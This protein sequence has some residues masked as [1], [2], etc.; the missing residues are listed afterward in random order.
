MKPWSV[1]GRVAALALPAAIALAPGARAQEGAA[2]PP[3]DSIV[4]VTVAPVQASPGASADAHV[5]ISVANGWH[6]NAN[7]ANPDYMIATVVEIAPV[8]GIKSGK[9]RYPAARQERLAFDP[10][11]IAVYTGDVEARVP[12]AIAADVRAGTQHLRGKLKFQS[13]ND[14]VC[15][16][17]AT[18]GFDLELRVA[19]APARGA[20]P[21]APAAG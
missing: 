16:A 14:Q 18:V 13:C 4:H 19:A 21:P 6:I 10:H 11:P 1:I 12:L 20:A 3:P 2:P 7:P 15:L 17:P 5:R 8:A 9:V